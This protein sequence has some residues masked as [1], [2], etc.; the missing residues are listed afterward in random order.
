MSVAATAAPVASAAP[1]ADTGISDAKAAPVDGAA[2]STD[3]PE[4]DFDGLKLKRS[5]AAKQLKRIKELER[6]AHEKFQRAAEIEKQK[7]S[8]EQQHNQLVAMLKDKQQRR[9]IMAELGVDTR[10]EA[11]EVLSEWLADQQMSPEARRLREVEA[12]NARY[13]QERE[14]HEAEQRKI[15]A[16]ESVERFQT[17]FHTVFSETVKAA[18]LPQSQEVLAEMSRRVEAYLAAGQTDKPLSEIADEIKQGRRGIR[19]E[20]LLSLTDEEIDNLPS[21]ALERIRK[22]LVAKAKATR[23]AVK[24]QTTQST[25]AGRTPNAAKPLLYSDF[26]RRIAAR[27]QQR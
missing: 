27:I 20:D 15:A 16:R 17:Q 24:P 9:A 11:E 6:G 5:E 2:A 23:P 12:E 10:A 22:R 1:A 19:D 26:D 8:I 13:K 18:G 14:A 7:T 4:V 21:D 3:D 25:I